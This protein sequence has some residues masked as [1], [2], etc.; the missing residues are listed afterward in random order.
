MR[1]HLGLWQN[2]V[3]CE[4]NRIGA[5]DAV[6]LALLEPLDRWA[7]KHGMG[8]GDVNFARPAGSEHLG[9][10]RDRAGRADHVVEHEHDL[11]LDR[12][13]DDVLLHGVVA[14]VRRL[15][16]IATVPPNRLAWPRARLMLPSSGLAI[17]SSSWEDSCSR[18]CSLS[19]G[20]A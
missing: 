12:P 7:A 10:T 1:Q 8:R 19:T 2:L 14:L 18:K 17:T 3:G 6:Q 5:D 13:A 4:R 9:R 20:A 16:I 15:S 11:S